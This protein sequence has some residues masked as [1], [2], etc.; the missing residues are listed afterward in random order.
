MKLSPHEIAYVALQVG[1]QLEPEATQIEFVATV[2]AESGGDTDVIAR[3]TTGD[4]IGQRD[5]GLGQISGRWQWPHL[6][7]HPNWRDPWV[8]LAICYSIFIDAG[9][10]FTPWHANT[11]GAWH[12]YEPDARFGVAHPFPPP[13]IWSLPRRT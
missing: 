1:W 7:E 2:L 10:T 8:N 5:H 13:D 9:R 3:S 11:S 6:V 4:N 12:T